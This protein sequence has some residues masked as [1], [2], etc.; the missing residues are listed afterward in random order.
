[1]TRREWLA[2]AALAA[3]AGSGKSAAAA[4]FIAPQE[5]FANPER[6]F[7]VQLPVGNTDDL[8]EIRKRGISLIQLNFDLKSYRDRPLDREALALLDASLHRIRAVG[9]KV[10]FRA[11]Y[12]FTDADYRVDPKDLGLIRSH[13]AA[14]SGILTAHAPWVF[15]VQAGMLGP[16]GEWHGS[17]HGDPPSLE[18]RLAVVNAWLTHLP[19]K[20]F[21]QVR[22]PLF[23]RDMSADL[24]RC[25]FHDDALLALP[26]DMGTFTEPGWDRARE[27]AWCAESLQAVPF[28]GESVPDSEPTPPARVLADLKTLHTTFLNSGYHGGTL[29]KWK[30][31]EVRGENLY[32]LIERSLGYR[33]AVVRVERKG[34]RGRLI[35]RNDGFGAPLTRKRVSFAWFDPAAGE[36]VGNPATETRSLL[37]WQPGPREIQL[38]FELP[39]AS[40]KGLVPAVRFADDSDALAEDGRHAIRLAGGNVRFA[41]AKGWNLLE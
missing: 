22:R 4:D 23:L 34:P 20:I 14:I 27:L 16:W 2:T 6:G 7:Y 3:L 31:S 41:A 35:L 38:P 36:I 13:I 12:G 21:L 26:D 1:M 30:R 10:I 32:E 8:A 9:M 28:G 5:D 39:P 15:V 29:A 24:K 33:L 25:G 37:A 18:S 17:V 40:G 19:E 11:A